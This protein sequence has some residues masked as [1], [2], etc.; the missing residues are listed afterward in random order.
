MQAHPALFRSPG[1]ILLSAACLSLALAKAG[2]QSQTGWTGA[3]GDGLW[4]NGANWTNGAPNTIGGANNN[5]ILNFG[6][7]GN[8]HPNVTNDVGSATGQSGHRIFFNA[9]AT[10]YTLWLKPE[11]GPNGTSLND[12]GGQLPKIQN[13]STNLQTVDMA[14]R[15]SG[16]SL[17]NRVGEIN[18]VK[19]DFVFTS[20]CVITMVT[21]TQLRFYSAPGCSVSFHGPI[22]N[23][24]DNTCALMTAGSGGV[25][26]T[27]NFYN[28]H[29]F[30]NTYINNGTVRLATNNV[31]TFPITLGDTAVNNAAAALLLDNGLEN[32]SAIVI[33]AGS[34]NARTIGNSG[35]G[36]GVATFSG[37]I[38][39]DANL[40]LAA[41]PAGTLRLTGVITETGAGSRSLTKTG[42]GR[43]ELTRDCTHS[44]STTISEGTLVLSGEGGM[45]DCISIVLG[46]GGI[47]DV[48]GI[49]FTLGVNQ[50]LR[51]NG[52]VI[53]EPRI[54][55]TLS[56]GTSLGTLTIGGTPVLAGTI[57]A[58]LDRTNVSTADKVVFGG[59][60]SF[61]GTLRVTN[62]GPALVN[63]DAFD[64]FDGDL[65]GS[66]AV[67][68]LPGGPLH[69]NTS[70][71]NVGGTLT[72][73]NASPVAQDLTLGVALGE[74]VSLVVLAGKYAPSDADGDS[75][76]VTAVSGPIL[77]RGVASTNGGAGFSYRADATAVLGTNTFTYTVT[78]E[79][80]A[81][82]TR[83]VTVLVYEPQGFNKLSGPTPVEAGLSL[84]YLGL[85][86]ERYALDETPGLTPPLAWTPVMT[87]TA[88]ETGLIEFLFT[89]VNA[90]GFFRTRHV[91]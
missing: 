41:N 89:P 40:V 13:D 65:D 71:L 24:T 26:A 10:N 56:P 43:V 57:V 19:G 36:S 82:D 59:G 20:N 29:S 90:A 87:N 49:S 37:P 42:A 72:F 74:S 30:T 15:I 55:G 69:W 80:G 50:S 61:G 77:G 75:I 39:L 58:E 18:P 84:R 76:S 91:P 68:E 67:L 33:R 85:P 9:G 17:S 83:T 44:G 6:P 35:F 81:T 62:L 5:R 16:Q 88:G 78:D 48:A 73:T 63:G 23:T 52:T 66:F 53:G 7:L 4:S 28:R 31:T 51:G 32:S 54:E 22:S 27:V 79:L 60:A 3:S 38:S 21:N 45:S 12:F 86:G 11:T 46:A 25:G 70:D 8:D 47:L 1:T 2:A 34:T 14:F 64:L